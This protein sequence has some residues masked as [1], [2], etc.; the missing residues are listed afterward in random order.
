MFP[1]AF[2]PN[3]VPRSYSRL[4]STY[5]PRRTSCSARYAS[6]HGSFMCARTIFG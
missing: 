2:S 6:V 1:P 4:N 5:R 3:M